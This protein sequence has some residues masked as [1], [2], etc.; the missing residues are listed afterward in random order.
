MVVSPPKGGN[1]GNMLLSSKVSSQM[2]FGMEW[3]HIVGAIHII[4]QMTDMA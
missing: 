3:T 4:P 1:S 2:K